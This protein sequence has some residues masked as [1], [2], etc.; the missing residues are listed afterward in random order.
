MREATTRKKRGEERKEIQKE[1]VE[2]A[3]AVRDGERERGSK[4]EI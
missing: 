1:R 3:V 2:Q 4:R